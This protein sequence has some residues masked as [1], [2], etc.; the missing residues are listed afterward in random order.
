MTRERAHAPARA[1]RA[2]IIGGGPAGSAAASCLAR[3]GHEVTLIARPR[4]STRS[5]VESIPPSA[6]KLLAAAGALDAIEAASF[7]PNGGNA[8]WWAGAPG[9]IE[10]FADSTGFQVDALRFER[11][12]LRAAE[13][14]GVHVLR[15]PVHGV[16]R[17]EEGG[18][19]VLHGAGKR[20]RVDWLIDASGRAGVLAREVRSAD[21]N[22][23]TL[24]LVRRWRR[25]GGWPRELATHTLVE[26]Y[27]DGW[28][29]SVPVTTEVRCVTAMVDPD[30]SALPRSAGLDVMYAAQ[31][32]RTRELGHHL[33]RA[34]PV[35]PV[36]ACSA[37]TYSARRF[38]WPGALLAGDAGCFIDPLSSYGVKKALASGW[39]AAIVLN[40][41]LS[42]D[43]RQDASLQL[44]ERREREMATTYERLAASF[45]ATAARAH[46]HPFWERRAATAGPLHGQVPFH[47]RVVGAEMPHT[48][49]VR[50][51]FEWIRR[52]ERLALEVGATVQTVSRPAVVGNRIEPVDHL[53]TDAWT[54]PLTHV[55]G[56]DLRRILRHA[57]ACD[58]VPGLY[59]ASA[60]EAPLPDF[61]AALA[62]ALAHGF[63]SRQTG[64]SP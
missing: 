58:D 60:R 27:L 47:D 34:Y 13:Q 24:A 20:T 38:A 49:A 46:P 64:A 37:T 32:A 9:R 25:D 43:G 26:S 17:A 4:R 11:E 40:T 61:L 2:A 51:A 55:R 35:G 22:C 57:D 1:P 30:R 53:A 31:L 16:H 50:A 3:W 44:F 12:L 56:V 14:S 5:L 29:W 7:L 21:R 63:L 45:A 48:P 42:D 39:L 62:F 19:S 41:V 6:R 52:S 18:W 54:E 10:S 15:E 33:E 23:R 36:W 8:V 28:A 59:A